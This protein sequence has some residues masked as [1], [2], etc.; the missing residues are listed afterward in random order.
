LVAGSNPA[1]PIISRTKMDTP[2]LPEPTVDSSDRTLAVLCH[3]SFFLGVGFLLPL[4]VYLVKRR[5]SYFVGFHS[6]EV[7]N[8]HLSLFI[9]AICCFPLMLVL[10]GIPL[11]VAVILLGMVCAIIGAVKASQDEYYHYPLAIRFF[12]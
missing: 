7:L 12:S 4:I 2:A 5:D 11:F 1:G 10:V 9:Y 6:R 3:I 8:F